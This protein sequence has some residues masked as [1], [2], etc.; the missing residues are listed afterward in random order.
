VTFQVKERV[1]RAKKMVKNAFS[2][3]QTIEAEKRSLYEQIERGSLA[4]QFLTDPFWPTILEPWIEEA[5]SEARL[6]LE[7]HNSP[8]PKDEYG[9]Y[10]TG[11]IQRLTKLKILVKKQL[12]EEARIA[13]QKLGL[14]EKQK[15]EQD[16]AP[17]RRFER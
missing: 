10:P 12:I 15:K 5:I 13:R 16:N 4:E 11:E 8:Y 17:R 7:N 1:F 3:R 2:S 9:F 14:L 6:A